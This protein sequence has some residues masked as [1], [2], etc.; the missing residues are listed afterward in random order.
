MQY[1]A[2]MNE[3]TQTPVQLRQAAA[4]SAFCSNESITNIPQCLT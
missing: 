1:E 4:Q 3:A 2:A